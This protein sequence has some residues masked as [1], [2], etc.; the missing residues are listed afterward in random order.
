V[1]V[2]ILMWKI[3]VPPPSRRVAKQVTLRMSA[4]SAERRDSRREA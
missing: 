1:G 2:A 3:T 4:I